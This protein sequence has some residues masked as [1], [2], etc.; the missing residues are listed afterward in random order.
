MLIKKEYNMKYLVTTNGFYSGTYELTVKKSA[1][2]DGNKFRYVSGH[3]FGCSKDYYV[4]SDDKA[5]N[6]LVKEHGCSVV[7]IVEHNEQSV[8]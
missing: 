6:L 1:F 8:V 4:D 2:H 5:I 7:D 3:P